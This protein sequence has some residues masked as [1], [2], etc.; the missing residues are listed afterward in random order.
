M[1]KVKAGWDCLRHYEILANGC[2]PH[3]MGIHNCPLLTLTHLPKLELMQ[4]NVMADIARKLSLPP[5]FGEY[6]ELANRLLKHTRKHLTTSAI[7]RY[8]VDKVLNDR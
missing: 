5:V 1:T 6:H 4:G 3:F 8:L 2:I 7:A